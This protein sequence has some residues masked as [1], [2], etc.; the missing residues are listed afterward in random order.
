MI[1][2]A[3]PDPKL[4]MVMIK[5]VR[6]SVPEVHRLI[7]RRCR[8]PLPVRP[9]TSPW[10]GRPRPRSAQPHVATQVRTIFDH[11]D[12]VHAQC[13]RVVDADGRTQPVPVEIDAEDARAG[14]GCSALAQASHGYWVE[15]DVVDETGDGLHRRVTL[16][17]AASTAPLMRLH[18]QNTTSGSPGH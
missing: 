12:A 15:A 11:A 10:A 2:Y 3:R 17:R 1:E 7:A 18:D 16:R 9:R 14:L 5:A 4:R 8:P 13:D 6:E